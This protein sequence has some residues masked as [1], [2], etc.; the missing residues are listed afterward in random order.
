MAMPGRH[1]NQWCRY[2]STVSAEAMQK[3][4]FITGTDTGVGKTLVSLLLMQALQAQGFKVLG[5]K[6][7]ASGG[8]WQSG[9]LVNEDALALQAQSSLEIPY[10]F[11][12]PYVFEPA[13]APHLAA[14]EAGVRIELAPIQRAFAELAAQADLVIVEGAGGWR[15]PLGQ[16]LEMSDLA[17]ALDLPVVLVVGLRLGCLNQALLS[18]ESIKNK[19]TRPGAWIANQVDQTMERHQENFDFLEKELNYP[20][21][22]LL[23]WN[24]RLIHSSLIKQI[25]I[26]NLQCLMAES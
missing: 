4:L 17:L 25:R 20:C 3:G 10:E 19:K 26:D 11:I 2:G 15:V 7:V 12:N 5:M 22:G 23:P 6:P 24:N 16:G 21:L 9:R 1:R 18:W 8:H 14:A 13:I